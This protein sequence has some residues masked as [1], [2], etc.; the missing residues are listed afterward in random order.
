MKNIV[1]CVFGN[2]VLPSLLLLGL[3]TSGGGCLYPYFSDPKIDWSPGG[4]YAAIETQETVMIIDR[5]GDIKFYSLWSMLDPYLEEYRRRY[6]DTRNFNWI[7]SSTYQLL[8]SYY[9]YDGGEYFPIH[10]IHMPDGEYK[11]PSQV[12][13][14]KLEDNW[15]LSIQYISQDGT[16]GIMYGS[17]SLEYRDT[18]SHIYNKKENIPDKADSRVIYDSANK[19]WVWEEYICEYKDIVFVCD[20]DKS[21]WAWVETSYEW[22][23]NLYYDAESSTLWWIYNY[24]NFILS[25]LVTCEPE[26][27][28]EQ[29]VKHG[30][31]EYFDD[32]PDPFFV[33]ESGTIHLRQVY[34][35]GREN[36]NEDDEVFNNKL[37]EYRLNHTTD[38]FDQIREDIFNSAY[39]NS[40]TAINP[41]GTLAA[42][43]TLKPAT[44]AITDILNN[45]SLYVEYTSSRK[46]K[47]WHGYAE[48]GRKKVPVW[49]DDTT[50][51]TLWLSDDPAHDLEIVLWDV[52]QDVLVPKVLSKDWTAEQRPQFLIHDSKID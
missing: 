18:V 20:P 16:D 29:P 21:E 36:D 28:I 50:L 34:S 51:C 26:L 12:Y 48:D 3:L 9:K 13:L 27:N 11:I 10:H 15:I 38:K 46:I 7:D 5:E 44:L 6:L 17:G 4:E 8:D 52:T 23:A 33:D 47:E 14:P 39:R 22:D 40:D 35:I 1:K 37:I 43:F 42:Y 31:L 24:D 19:Q 45:T 25:A 41:S 30:K 49:L 32:L 2:T